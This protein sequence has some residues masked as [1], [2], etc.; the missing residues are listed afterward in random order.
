MC[1]FKKILVCFNFES[2]IWYL[3]CIAAFNLFQLLMWS[4]LN[5]F[6]FTVSI[7]L[8]RKEIYYFFLI[9]NPFLNQPKDNK[10][11][12]TMMRNNSV[13]KNLIILSVPQFMLL[14]FLAL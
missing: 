10:D 8:V 5:Y 12:E 1:S 11:E 13:M 3:K 14:F 6:W 9:F 7:K 2:K 4:I